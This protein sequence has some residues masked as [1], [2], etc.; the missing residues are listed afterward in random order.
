ML[1]ITIFVRWSLVIIRFPLPEDLE[2]GIGC[3]VVSAGRLFMFGGINLGERN[4]RVGF[5]HGLGSLGV[6]WGKSLAMSTPG[7]IWRQKT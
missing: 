1:Q 3:D 5:C 2:H 7:D 4:G 6:Y